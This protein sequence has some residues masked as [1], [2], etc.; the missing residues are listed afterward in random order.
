MLFSFFYFINIADDSI[1]IATS[2]KELKQKA[3]LKSP[4]LEDKYKDDVPSTSK[5]FI[6]QI[7]KTSTTPK[8]NQKVKNSK[9]ETKSRPKSLGK[10]R[11]CKK[12]TNYF[13]SNNSNNKSQSDQV[14]NEKGRKR[15]CVET[16]AVFEVEPQT[17]RLKS[18]PEKVHKLEVIP[19]KTKKAISKSKTKP[20][21]KARKTQQK[22]VSKNYSGNRSEDL[23]S[24]DCDINSNQ[25][26]NLVSQ[27]DSRDP[28]AETQNLYKSCEG[29]S[30]P[31]KA[32]LPKRKR[33]E[34]CI[35]TCNS[36]SSRRMLDES[37]PEKQT[38]VSLKRF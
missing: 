4:R 33:T 6:N 2:N 32:P 13:S 5:A 38:E 18:S 7:R 26:I 14:E 9:P 25:I 10:T 29:Y 28:P 22:V 1:P 35:I 27:E 11:A 24:D 8:H 31:S 36:S 20:Q 3:D 17:K 12:I 23:V 15:K 19:N 37:S 16:K 34:D 21:P 30:S